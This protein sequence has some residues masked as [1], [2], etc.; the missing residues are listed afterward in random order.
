MNGRLA[1]LLVRAYPREWRARYGAEFEELLRSES[2]GLRNVANVALA[3][4][5][6]RMISSKSATKSVWSLGDVATRIS[7][8][9]PIVMSLIAL[10][11]VA[12]HIF[13]FGTAREPDEGAVAHIWQI[14]MAG[15]VPLLV[16]FA[17]K[18]LPRAPK[19]ALYVLA[20]QA[21][22]ALA[23]IAPVFLLRL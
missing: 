21:G 7:A 14:L 2:G 16:F 13:F 20:A 23:S 17:M 4:L 8:I 11:A 5:H 10:S 18:W 15:Q 3:A 19:Q 9:S 22:A 12:C 1:R 6:E